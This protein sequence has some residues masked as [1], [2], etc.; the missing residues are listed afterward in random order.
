MLEFHTQAEAAW[1]DTARWTIKLDFVKKNKGQM[2]D[3][4]Q[5][6]CLVQLDSAGACD[7]S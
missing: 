2:L 5:L 4:L 1:I 3:S 6:A 7:V